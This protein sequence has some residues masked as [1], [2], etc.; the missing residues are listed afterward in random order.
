[1]TNPTEVWVACQHTCPAALV[2]GCDPQGTEM[3]KN[4][5]LKPYQAELCINNN[6]SN[7]NNDV[8]L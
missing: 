1:M 2:C 6:N 5:I 8:F 7:S 4:P 3:I